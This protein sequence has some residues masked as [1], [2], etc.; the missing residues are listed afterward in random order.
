MR[1]RCCR[2]GGFSLLL[3]DWLVL[4]CVNGVSVS[5]E[6]DRHTYERGR[7]LTSST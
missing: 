4:C 2:D 3:G 6:G 7:S 5:I 1:C